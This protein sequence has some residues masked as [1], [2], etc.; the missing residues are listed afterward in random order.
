MTKKPYYEFSDFLK[1]YFPCK[2]QKISINAGF[3]CPNRDGTKGRGG[4]TY[5]NN[6]TFNPAYCHTAKSVSDQMDEGI[7]FF[8]RKYPDMKYIA[9]FQ[10]YT[11]TYAPLDT[12]LANYEEA[13]AFPGV[14]GLII[15]TRPDCMP[16]ELLDYLA[17]RAKTT[18]I[19][20]EYGIESTS[21]QTLL[22]IN[23]GHTCDEAID[24]VH[25]THQKGIPTGAHLILGLP[26]ED[27]AQILHHADL[28]SA[29]PLSVLK[30]HQLQIIRHTA[31][32]QELI[33]HP[34][35]FRFYTPQE[36][37]DLV[38]DF[39]ERLR[40]GIALDRFVSQS[41][42]ELL[43]VPRWGLKNHEFTALLNK[44]LAARQTTQGAL[45]QKNISLTC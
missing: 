32:E 36:Y 14:V 17:A 30:L 28:V 2:V 40:P 35:R 16:N 15:G 22:H 27:R 1:K 5:C 6:R 18:F 9:Y 31:M 29:L 25:R 42:E 21:D 11:N 33:K 8:A 23:R 20:I 38:I 39:M 13:L 10:A 3:T 12:L 24:A 45:Y 44:R 43:I 19:L 41:P 7:R 26:N 4:C 37:V 34:E